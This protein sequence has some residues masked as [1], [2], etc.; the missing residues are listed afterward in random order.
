MRVIILDSD[1]ERLVFLKKAVC[2]TNP[3]VTVDT[4]QNVGKLLEAMRYLVPDA[5]F[6]RIE[7][8][9]LS[10]LTLGQV[11]S[12]MFP[13]VNLIFMAEDDK[14]TAEALRLRASGYLKEPISREAVQ[15]EL[16]SLRYEPG[17]DMKIK[18]LG[19]QEI[20]AGEQPLNFKYSKTRDLMNYLVVRNGAVCSTEDIEQYLWDKA[21]KSHKSYLQNI[22]ADLS[23]SLKAAGCEDVLI[24]RRG[25]VGINMN[26]VRKE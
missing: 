12:G 18:I 4:F 15:E 19:N 11:L 3:N 9:P 10:G 6:L 1:L 16:Q 7:M 25:Q 5:A 23:S 20:F 2:E 13:R 14:Y 21:D 24:R 8:E 26:V 22:L 17:S